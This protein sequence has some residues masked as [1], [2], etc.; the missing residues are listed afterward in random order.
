M[1]GRGEVLG[2]RRVG[3]MASAARRRLPIRNVVIDSWVMVRM[4]RV[5]WRIVRG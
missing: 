4:K 5:I 1:V 3:R 2:V